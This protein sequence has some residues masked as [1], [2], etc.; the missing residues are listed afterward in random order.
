MIY[1]SYYFLSL[2]YAKYIALGDNF[3]YVVIYFAS[4]L[5]VNS[6]K[7]I[8]VTDLCPMIPY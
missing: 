3:V 5:S 1:N 4:S 8:G 6:A 2:Q 7:I